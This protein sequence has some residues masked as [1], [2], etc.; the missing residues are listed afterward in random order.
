MSVLD[1]PVWDTL[2]THHAGVAIGGARARRFAPEIGPLAGARDDDAASLAELAALIP[3]GGTVL[4]LQADPIVLPPDVIA[5]STAAGVQMVSTTLAPSTSDPRIVGLT[6]DDGPMMFALATLT[7]PG[8]FAAR[9]S[10]L[11]EFWGIKDG[12]VLVAMAGERMKHHGFA[13]VSGVCTH[14]DARGRGLARALSLH[15]AHR[16]RERGDTPYLHS[17]AHNTAAIKLYE[18]LGFCV[19]REMFIATIAAVR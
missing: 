2:A 16:I 11:G 12:G 4:L 15:V 13:E 6:A 18:S 10:S 5:H 7:R 14:P 3:A 1:R 9:T 8:P 19:R 17:Y